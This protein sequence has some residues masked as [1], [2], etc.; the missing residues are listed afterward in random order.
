M[1]NSIEYSGL[2]WLNIFSNEYF[3]FCFE[4]EFELNNQEN[5]GNSDNSDNQDNVDNQDNH[6]HHDNQ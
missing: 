3:G 2:Y 1:N 4:L 5:Q 6:S